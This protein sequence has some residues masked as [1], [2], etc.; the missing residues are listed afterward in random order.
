MSQMDDGLREKRPVQNQRIVPRNLRM[1]AQRR[2]HV[3]R[4]H[5][6]QI[7]IAGQAAGDRRIELRHNLAH[8]ARGLVRLAQKTVN[9]GRLG[10]RLV[11]HIGVLGAGA[12][13]ELRE[14]CVQAGAGRRR[15]SHHV[16]QRT[17]I[18]RNHPGVL[19]GGALDVALIIVIV[20]TVEDEAGRPEAVGAPHLQ[21]TGVGVEKVAPVLGAVHGQDVVG[22]VAQG[23]GE[24]A[25]GKIGAAILQRHGD[26]SVTAVLVLGNVAQV[27]IIALGIAFVNSVGCH[28]CWIH[29]RLDHVRQ[30]R[31]G[32][33]IGGAESV[34]AGD[35]GRGGVP[36]HHP[37]VPVGNTPARHGPAVLGIL[38]ERLRH[39]AAPRG[40]HHGDELALVAVNIPS[41]KE[42]VLGVAGRGVDLAIEAN[43]LAVDIADHAGRLQGMIHHRVKSLRVGLRPAADLHLVQIAVPGVAGGVRHGV[44]A[45]AGKRGSRTFRLQVGPGIGHADIRNRRPGQ[46]SSPARQI[47]TEGN[48]DFR[49]GGVGAAGRQR[50]PVPHPV[51]GKGMVEDRVEI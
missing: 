48:A 16:H 6:A 23:L 17:Q 33:K 42:L 41:G 29:R 12:G 40:I 15:S 1:Q 9:P 28:R 7:V 31:F 20:Q 24:T 26:R 36:H 30:R 18:E 27:Q 38:H 21:I 14:K 10:T 35:D 37:R 3:P 39:V 49:S 2:Q 13:V 22:G 44:E 43:V 25:Q 46:D 32:V 47:E 11:A 34:Q 8:D 19:G 4:R 45:G 51:S 50:R 5:L